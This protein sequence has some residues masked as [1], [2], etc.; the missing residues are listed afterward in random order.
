MAAEVPAPV[1]R[2]ADAHLARPLSARH[3]NRHHRG[4]GRGHVHALR[5]R[6]RLVPARTRGALP[7]PRGREGEPGPPPRAAP[8][9]RG[10]LPRA[11]HEGR[12]GAEPPEAHRQDRRGAD[13]PAQA[14]HAERPHTPRRAA[15]LRNRDVP[16]R[17]HVLQLRRRAQRAARRLVQCVARRQ[18]GPHR[19]PSC[20][21]S[22]ARASPPRARR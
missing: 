9:V 5:G 16:L 6:P 21:S 17:E 22:R 12:A 11:G 20:A 13:R 2:H 15:S 1:P 10:P 18:G 8:A 4:G 14:L 19:L 7:A 3:A